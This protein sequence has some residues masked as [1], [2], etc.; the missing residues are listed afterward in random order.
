METAVRMQ[1]KRGASQIKLALGGGVISYS[2]PIDT[3][4]YTPEEI[5][6]AVLV[7]SEWT[8]PSSLVRVAE[9]LRAA[10]KATHLPRSPGAPKLTMQELLAARAG[11]LNE[12]LTFLLN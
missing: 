2:D 5:R 4:Q 11:T 3:L 9:T 1:L 7:A 10:G 12:R 6:A 8:S